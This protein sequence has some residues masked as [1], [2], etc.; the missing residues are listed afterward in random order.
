MN[1][2]PNNPIGFDRLISL[3]AKWNRFHESNGA[4][5]LSASLN[6]SHEIVGRSDDAPITFR[7]ELTGAELLVRCPTDTVVMEETV[8]QPL[9]R[10]RET[11]QTVSDGDNVEVGIGRGTYGARKEKTTHH[12]VSQVSPF[13]ATTQD[14]SGNPI[15]EFQSEL[16]TVLYGP[17]WNGFKTVAQIKS[18]KIPKPHDP[19]P[20]LF[21]SAYSDDLK[22]SKPVIKNEKS[23][24]GWQKSGGKRLVALAYIKKCVI[25]DFSLDV[26]GEIEE[27]H[28]KAT[29]LRYEPSPEG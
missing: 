2:R 4:G 11:S 27:P 18:L 12:K 21:V 3:K 24:L 15:F 25:D 20:V 22:I 29:L 14:A 17:V 9:A 8:L 23:R 7:L 26:E 13:V 6:F 5:T 19:E 28:S 1:S 10:E 16:N